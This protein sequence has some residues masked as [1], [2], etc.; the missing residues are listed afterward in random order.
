MPAYMDQFVR[1]HDPAALSR[2]VR[3]RRRQQDDGA[4]KP[5]GHWRAY[6]RTD[7]QPDALANAQLPAQQIQIAEPERIL[8]RA[9]S[10]N[11]PPEAAN[12]HDRRPERRGATRGPHQQDQDSEAPTDPD[13]LVGPL[14]HRCQRRHAWQS[15]LR[16]RL[17]LKLLQCRDRLAREECLGRHCWQ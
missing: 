5:A 16:A 15:G 4:P 2:P 14:P 10:R 7:Q 11:E 13:G 1:E 8:E 12:A 3:R 9:R 17:L 6:I